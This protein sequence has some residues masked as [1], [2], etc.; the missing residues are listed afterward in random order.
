MGVQLD[1]VGVFPNHLPA[2]YLT[3][4]DFLLF[5][6]TFLIYMAQLLQVGYVE[7]SFEP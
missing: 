5:F 3:F 4:I 1:N 6:F 7:V 2:P